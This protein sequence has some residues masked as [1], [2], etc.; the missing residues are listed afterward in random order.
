[1]WENFKKKMNLEEF[2]AAAKENGISDIAIKNIRMSNNHP[3]GT[4]VNSATGCFSEIP[5]EKTRCSLCKRFPKR[6]EHG[7]YNICMRCEHHMT[8]CGMD[9]DFYWAV[10]NVVD[11]DEVNL[12]FS[13]LRSVRKFIEETRLKK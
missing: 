6:F 2:L 7:Q 8:E 5:T 13:S 11:E 3:H 4:S 1:M 12:R 10:A 9:D